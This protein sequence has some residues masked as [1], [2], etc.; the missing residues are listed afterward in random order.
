[1]RSRGLLFARDVNLAGYAA[2]LGFLV[3]FLEGAIET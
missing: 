2:V 3:G 1:M